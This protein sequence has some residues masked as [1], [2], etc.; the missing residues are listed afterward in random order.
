MNQK[1]KTVLKY[2]I[3][4]VVVVTS[5]YFYSF[6]KM[7]DA[8]VLQPDNTF[9]IKCDGKNLNSVKIL[10]SVSGDAEGNVDFY[11][12]DEAGKEIRHVSKVAA[13]INDAQIVKFSFDKIGDSK[14][15]NYTARIATTSERIVPVNDALLQYS[16][17]GFRV[18][19]MV[20]FVL[21]IAYLVVLAKTL[22]FI[23]RK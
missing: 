11:L 22:G 7:E 20:V 17:T 3:L 2:V 12:Y 9:L 8:A 4:T 16:Y 15:K 18:E 5:A 13:D 19:T 1:L 21:C 6:V 10:F 23:F 14:G